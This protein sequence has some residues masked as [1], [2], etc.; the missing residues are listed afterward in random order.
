MGWVDDCADL[1]LA[2]GKWGKRRYQ[3]NEWKKKL[4]AVTADLWREDADLRVAED[5]VKL[6][7]Q[8][9]YTGA[10]LLTVEERVQ[11]I[12]EYKRKKRKP[13]RTVATKVRKKKPV[14][15]AA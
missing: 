13:P 1:L 10:E 11:A 15:K 2:L 14:K 8:A 6:A 9:G 4:E 5:T 3:S 12:R 7:Q